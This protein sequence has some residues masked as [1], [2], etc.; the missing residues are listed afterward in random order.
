MSSFEY[1]D[2]FNKAQDTGIYHMF[3]FDMVGSKKMSSD[4]RFY[5]QE[6]M[7]ELMMKIFNH[8]KEIEKKTNKRI[9][10]LDCIDIE[11][12]DKITYKNQSRFGILHEPFCYG[13]TFGFT[14]YRDSL[15]VEEV[16]DI[17]NLYKEELQIDFNF[18]IA[19]GYYET[20]L[21]EEGNKLFFRGYAI[22]L[23]STSHKEDS[24]IKKK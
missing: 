5:S 8:L 17:Y 16:L 15:S 23:L 19:D 14:I 2:L 9:L 7:I 24:K 3:T 1:I 4:E 18:H 10:I 6:K 11:E 21:W 22:D 12:I 13:D 20:N